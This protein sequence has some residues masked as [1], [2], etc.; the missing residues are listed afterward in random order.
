MPQNG[1]Y[2]SHPHARAESSP[3]GAAQILSDWVSHVMSDTDAFFT[4]GP[5]SDYALSDE[6]ASGGLLTFPSALVTP[7][8]SNNT[9]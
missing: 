2:G 6:P 3:P 8:S 7:E 4:P 9:V 1:R 5:T